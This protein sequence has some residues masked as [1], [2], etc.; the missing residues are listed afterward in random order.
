MGEMIGDISIHLDRSCNWKCCGSKPVD[1]DTALYITRK[2]KA[3]PLKPPKGKNPMESLNASVRHL[4]QYF[5]QVAEQIGRDANY[6]RIHVESEAG[7]T[8]DYDHPPVIT[9]STLQRINEAIK[10]IL[11]DRTPESEFESV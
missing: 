11:T 1:E 5:R 4:H 3:V 8:L 9:L 10:E 7:V 6:V 2:Y